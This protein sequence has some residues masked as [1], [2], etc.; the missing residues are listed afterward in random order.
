[1]EFKD[2]YKIL[3][4]PRDASQDDIRKAYRKLARKYHPDVSK[5]ANAETRMRDVN[6]ANDVLRDAEKRA[7]YDALAAGVSGG[8][9]A[10]P[11][12]GWDRDFEFSGTGGA[13]DAD[14]QDFL[15]GMFKQAARKRQGFAQGRGD[16][17]G[18]G[19]AGGFG[20]HPAGQTFKMRGEDHHADIEITLEDSFS[21]V[22]RELS[23]RSVQLDDQGRPYMG[24]RTLSVRIPTGVREGQMIRLSGQGMPGEGGGEPGD[25]F[26][27]VRF[28]PHAVYQADGRDLN[29]QLPITPWE[30]ALGGKVHAP[31]MQGEVEVHIPAGSKQGGKLRLRGKGLPGDPAGD[32]YLTLD[33][34]WPPADNDAARAAYRQLAEAAAFNPRRHLGVHS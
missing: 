33:I 18:A 7:E 5:E 6:E 3:E 24:T 31:T 9:G 21:G 23:L 12:P 1:M 34:V 29:M 11:P 30:A 19:P 8:N 15:N 13:G 20:G 28:A 25:L 16:Q 10:T 26:L 4:V 17:R 14:F 32:L 27:T 2:Y 22:T